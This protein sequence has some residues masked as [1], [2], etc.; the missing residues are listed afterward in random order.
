MPIPHHIFRSYNIRGLLHEVTP[1]VAEKAAHALLVITRAKKVVVGRDMRQTSPELAQAAINYFVSKGV[2]VLDIG[3][4]TSSMYNYAVTSREDIGA[5]FMVTA[6]HNPAEYNGI[7]MAHP[8]GLPIAGTEVLANCDTPLAQTGGEGSVTSLDIL[9]SYLEACKKHVNI[10]DVRGTKI[11]VDYG[12]GMGV[13]SM[14]PLCEQLGIEVVELYPEPDARFPNHEANPAKEETLHDL[15]KK[16]REVG[17]DFGVAID[18]DA[19]RVAFVDNEGNAVQGDL[20]LALMASDRLSR[21]T[22][23]RVLYSINASWAVEDAVRAAGGQPIACPVGNTKIIKLMQEYQGMLGG[24]VSSHFF[25]PEFHNLE[26]V[27]YAFLTV[28]GIWKRSGKTFADLLRPLRTYHNSQ[29]MNF[30][31]EDKDGALA[32]IKERYEQ[33]AE[34][35]ITIDGLRYEFGRTW[36][37]LVRKSNT[38]PLIRVTIETNDAALLEEK[39]IE[40]KEVLKAFLPAHEA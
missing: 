3:M 9:P 26:A 40:V 16:V 33:E 5:G 28:L 10:P 30:E 37:M 14:R 12:N 19:D 36:W 13:V 8:T 21:E 35:C 7:K 6:S 27:D 20:T 32:A 24:E 1:E 2:E 22:G 34:K 39:R 23:G 17:A 15:K 11:V 29:E 25:F 4:C 38:E 18:G 31:V